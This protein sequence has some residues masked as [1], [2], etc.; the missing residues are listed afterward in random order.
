M[1]WLGRGRSGLSHPAA[2]A[3]KTCAPPPVA[4]RR[5]GGVQRWWRKTTADTPRGMWRDA[6][7]AHLCASF[8][9]I[10]FAP[11]GRGS[12][13]PHSLTVTG[14]VAGGHAPPPPL[15]LQHEFGKA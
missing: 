14:P 1:R 5:G 9:P 2:G 10:P 13:P 3:R 8:R 11:R 12:P 4:T 6:V 7:L 15:S